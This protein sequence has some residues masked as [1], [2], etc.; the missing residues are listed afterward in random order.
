MRQQ[1]YEPPSVEVRTCVKFQ[2]LRDPVARDAGS[3]KRAGVGHCKS[4]A[5]SHFDLALRTLED[6]RVM[7]M[8]QRLAVL[9]T[10]VIG[11]IAG[12]FRRPRTLQIGRSRAS[13]Y[14]RLQDLAPDQ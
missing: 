6:P 2:R 9:N 13:Q 14:S 5:G 11:E 1:L 3:K 4:T 10:L 12:M 7:T 8:G